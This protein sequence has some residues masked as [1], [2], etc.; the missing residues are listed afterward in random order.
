[1]ANPVKTVQAGKTSFSYA[2]IKVWQLH[3]HHLVFRAL[4]PAPCRP[5]ARTSNPRKPPPPADHEWRDGECLPADT[6]AQ[7]QPAS[8]LLANSDPDMLVSIKTAP[9]PPRLEASTQPDIES[10]PL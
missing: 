1:M 2:A 7:R 5:G 6:A 4:V 3:L 9:P 8:E 10:D